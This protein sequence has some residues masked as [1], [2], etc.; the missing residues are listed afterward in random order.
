MPPG[1]WSGTTT[2]ASSANATFTGGANNEFGTSVALN[3]TGTLALIGAIRTGAAYIFEAPGGV[4]NGTTSAS[5]AN[6]TFTQG[7]ISDDFG[8]SVALSSDGK[9]ALIGRLTTTL[10]GITPAQR[11]SSLCRQ[12]AGA[13]QHRVK[14][15]RN[16]HWG[17]RR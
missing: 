10:P 13:A 6:A 4:W 12:V 3:S 7:A 8:C 9:Q 15:E 2:A 17:L 14:S 16:L 5:A 11:I 1:G